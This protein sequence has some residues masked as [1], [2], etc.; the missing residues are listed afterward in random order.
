V[1]GSVTVGE[2]EVSVTV[3]DTTDLQIVPYG[4]VNVDATATAQAVQGPIAP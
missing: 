2:M 1:T 3:T 4:S